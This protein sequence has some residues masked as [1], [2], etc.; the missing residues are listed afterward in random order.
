MQRYTFAVDQGNSTT[1]AAIF[2]GSSLIAFEKAGQH[3]EENLEQWILSHQCM[4][5]IISS[6]REDAESFMR[7]AVPPGVIRMQPTIKL[8]FDIA[9]ETPQTLGADRVANAAAALVQGHLPNVLIIDCGSCL[10]VTCV[11]HNTLIGGSISP[12]L[13]M[14]FKALQAFTGKL[15]LIET[16]PHEVL[17]IGTST[18]TSIQSGVI[19][20]VLAEIEEIIAAYCRKISPLS[21]IITGGDAG[22][23]VPRLKSPIFAEPFLTLM[24]LHEIY[25]YQLSHTH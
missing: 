14:R 8:P 23:F 20:G 13:S 16:I 19:L 21:V 7:H 5:G 3:Q 11:A 18:A 9:Y 22:H 12:G 25:H 24:G 15:P 1:K 17:L 6:V 4:G 2:D 10:T